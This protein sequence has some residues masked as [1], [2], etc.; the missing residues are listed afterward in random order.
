MMGRMN[1]SGDGLRNSLLC[2]WIAKHWDGSSLSPELWR[3]AVKMDTRSGTNSH[4]HGILVQNRHRH[5]TVKGTDA[6]LFSHSN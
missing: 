6:I 1:N 4:V 2:L 3:P 5:F